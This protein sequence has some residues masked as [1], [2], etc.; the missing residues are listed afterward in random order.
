MARSGEPGVADL[1]WQSG[2]P[3]V[4]DIGRLEC[5]SGGPIGSVIEWRIHRVMDLWA[6]LG[7]R[8]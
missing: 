5:E 1:G 6:G 2:G 3:G 8:P 7:W 4:I